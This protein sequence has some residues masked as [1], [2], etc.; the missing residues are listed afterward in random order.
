N[1]S[2]LPCRRCLAPTQEESRLWRA[3]DRGPVGLP[4]FARLSRV[5][6]QS[7]GRRHRGCGRSVVV[8]F[9][10]VVVVVVEFQF[11]EEEIYVGD[12]FEKRKRKRR[13]GGGDLC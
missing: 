11:G 10:I 2:V 3:C 1:H 7:S 6:G 4:R 9:G 13:R 12:G 8:S 5:R